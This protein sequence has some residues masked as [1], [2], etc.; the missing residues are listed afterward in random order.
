MRR[1]R[2]EQ[3]QVRYRPDLEVPCGSTVARAVLRGGRQRRD[4]AQVRTGSRLGAL[5]MS[6]SV[7]RPSD[8]VR[9]RKRRSRAAPSARNRAPSPPPGDQG[10][11]SAS[12]DLDAAQR[13]ARR[14]PR[15]CSRGAGRECECGAFDRIL[16]VSNSPTAAKSLCIA[17][18][19]TPTCLAPLPPGKHAADDG[20]DRQR[21]ERATAARRNR[22]GACVLAKVLTDQLVLVDA[23]E[24]GPRAG[25]RVVELAGREGRRPSVRRVSSDRRTSAH[26]QRSSPGRVEALSFPAN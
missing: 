21:R 16:S 4:R 11:R 5:A 15:A 24:S 25:G 14:R 13:P 10:R 1:H 7:A 26:S 17:D 20:Q 6:A 22:F 19:G 23:V 8:A 12:D 18:R 2:P 3:L 9:R